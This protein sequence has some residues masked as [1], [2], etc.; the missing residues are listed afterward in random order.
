MRYREK[1]VEGDLD[2]LRRAVGQAWDRGEDPSAS[3]WRWRPTRALRMALSLRSTGGTLTLPTLHVDRGDE[4]PPELAWG[5]AVG[6]L[7]PLASLLGPSVGGGRLARALSG[8]LPGAG[9]E[10]VV[11]Q[12]SGDG[13]RGSGGVLVLPY[14]REGRTGLE[15]IGADDRPALIAA[16]LRWWKHLLRDEPVSGELL[17]SLR[18]PGPQRYGW[19]GEERTVQEGRVLHVVAGPI[20]DVRLA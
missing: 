10:R 11:W 1:E 4:N 18:V 17:P 20:I 15:V 5:L 12:T 6:S 14:R 2:A 8:G 9:G 13:M 16:T 19:Q 3:P 7:A